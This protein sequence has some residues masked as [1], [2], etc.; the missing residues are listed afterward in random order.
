MVRD[1]D[2]VGLQEAGFDLLDRSRSPQRRT[3]SSYHTTQCTWNTCCKR[4]HRSAIW[5]ENEQ[6]D[7]CL[8]CMPMWRHVS[9]TH[10]G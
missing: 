5:V 6:V 9:Y 2:Q 7:R 8:P 3:G 1:L 4:G 10:S